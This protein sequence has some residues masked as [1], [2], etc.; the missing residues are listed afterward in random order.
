MP[1]TDEPFD[2]I[3]LLLVQLGF[4]VGGRFAAALAPT[5]LEPRDF[6]VLQ[7]VVAG[8]GISQQALGQLLG[9]SATRLVFLIDDMESKGLV[10][11]RTSPT[12]RRARALHATAAGRA[13][14]KK[15][16]KVRRQEAGRLGASLGPAA[17]AQLVTYLRA[18]A[19]EQ[20]IEPGA[21]P[22][23]GPPPRASR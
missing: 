8:P 21:L 11:R 12:D 9:I 5:G 15:A 14:L 16:D 4:H 10:E 1:A 22:A 19:A 20:G 23:G 3:G 13:A 18:L 2:D 6:G 7:R 17:R